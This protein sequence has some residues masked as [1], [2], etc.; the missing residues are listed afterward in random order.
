[1]GG[2][3]SF[4]GSWLYGALIR[5]H[6]SVNAFDVFFLFGDILLTI[7]SLETSEIGQFAFE[8]FDLFADVFGD[9][10]VAA[11]QFKV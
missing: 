1:M 10:V 2:Y 6:E 8:L 7:Y 5:I 11:H 3:S 9:L 4:E